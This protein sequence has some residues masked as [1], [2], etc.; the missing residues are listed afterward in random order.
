MTHAS[1]VLPRRRALARLATYAAAGAG[2][3]SLLACS[4]EEAGS[5]QV[6]SSGGPA[7]VQG[8]GDKVEFKYPD[9]PSFDLVYLADSLGY[10][11]GTTTRPRYIGKVAAPQIIPLVGTGE[12]DFGTR[13]VPLVISAVAAGA[14]LKVV[15]AGGKTLEE[16]PHMKYF[17]RKDSGIRTPK[18][19][20]GKTVGFNSFGACAE[21]V[22]KTF[23]R[24]H[25]VDVSKINWIVVPDNQNEQTV[26]TGNVDLAIIHPPHSGGAEVNPQLVKLWSDYDLD[27]GLGGMAP[28]SGHGKFIRQH[29]EA[30][31]DVVAAI[32]KAANWVNANPDEAR[33]I[34]SE[35][36]NMP[37][38]K[39]E[40]FAYIENLVITEPPIQYYID[41][42]ENEGKVPKGK[43]AVKDIYTNEFNPFAAAAA[44]AAT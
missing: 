33:R 14:D 2:G 42:L 20:E 40:R 43:V 12:I 34:T 3:L 27:Q 37:L 26:E 19:L 28:Y 32:A 25:G 23:L 8:V 35:R 44:P 10:F 9:N 36:I 41:I 15:A 24:Q 38:E 39:V 21:F 16:A 1:I 29:P 5:A 22:T 11:E 7:V 13:M 4:K 6:S 30:T 31:R 17:V 18:D